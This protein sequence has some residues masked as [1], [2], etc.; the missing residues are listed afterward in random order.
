MDS[1]C[2]GEVQGRDRL[3]LDTVILC[4]CEREKERFP[5]SCSST[6]EPIG[7]APG[8]LLTDVC[9][10]S[11]DELWPVLSCL[12]LAFRILALCKNLALCPV[13]L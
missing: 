3:N 8:A 7:R 10:H 2:V 5:L 1:L 13:D 11:L 12:P 4:V 9:F 6:L